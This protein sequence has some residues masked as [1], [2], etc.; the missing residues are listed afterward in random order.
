MFYKRTDPKDGFLPYYT[1]L[2]EWVESATYQALI[3]LGYSHTQ[4]SQYDQNWVFPRL[5]SS[6]GFHNGGSNIED[7]FQLIVNFAG[8]LHNVNKLILMKRADNYNMV[9]VI[10]Q[11]QIEYSVDGTT[12]L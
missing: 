3:D 7:D 5:D 6:T 10:S 12:W 8:N 4:S 11:I 1:L 9:A 2:Q